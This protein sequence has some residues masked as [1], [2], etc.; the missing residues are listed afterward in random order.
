M[1]EQRVRGSLAVL[2]TIELAAGVV[3]FVA[4]RR[5]YD[6]IVHFGAINDHFVRDVATLYVVF[7]LSLLV[8]SRI[9]S[10]R[11]PVLALATFTNGLFALVP[12]LS[13]QRSLSLVGVI[14]LV[15]LLASVVAFALL[16][17]TAARAES[18]SLTGLLRELPS[19]LRAMKD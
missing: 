17:R 3:G 19:A 1:S 12:L 13:V 8:A 6:T 10:W 16:L 4:P 11:V 9:R 18:S 14:D 2:G 5:L 7:G 15:L